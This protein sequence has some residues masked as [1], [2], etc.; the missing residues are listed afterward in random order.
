MQFHV[1]AGEFRRGGPPELD[2]VRLRELGL[3]VQGGFCRFLSKEG[4]EIFLLPEM[5]DFKGSMDP[6]SWKIKRQLPGTRGGRVFSSVQDGR[7]IDLVVHPSRRPEEIT[8]RGFDLKLFPPD[9]AKNV[10]KAQLIRERMFYEDDEI[11]VTY[12]MPI[13]YIRRRDGTTEEVFLGNR[14][15]LDKD[16]HMN[17][18]GG[19]Q[20]AER[21]RR[22]LDKIEDMRYES[23]NFLFIEHDRYSDEY[24]V[25]FEKDARGRTVA[26]KFDTEFMEV[27]RKE[28]KKSPNM[29]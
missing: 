1:G 6:S 22:C 19:A 14:N 7:E 18:Y 27:K 5:I 21:V 23:P 29:R 10:L 3:D 8:K 2:A 13:G 17:K 4:D 16:L 9:P 12:E 28:A 24:D 25:M 15:G 20:E 26:I 11:V